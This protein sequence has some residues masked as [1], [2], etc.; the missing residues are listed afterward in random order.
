MSKEEYYSK[1]KRYIYRKFKEL[2]VVERD[3]GNVLYIRYNNEIYAQILIEKKSGFV[4]YSYRLSNKIYKTIRLEE[5]DF[6]IFLKS[7]VEETFQVKVKHI[8]DVIYLARLFN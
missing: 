1:I 2:E 5:T 8:Y 3:N 6:E 4:Y 7:W